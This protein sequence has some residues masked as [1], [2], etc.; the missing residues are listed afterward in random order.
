MV[1]KEQHIRNE[2]ISNE[3]SAKIDMA[4]TYINKSKLVATENKIDRELDNKIAYEFASET[5]TWIDDLYSLGSRF[6]GGNENTLVLHIRFPGS[7]RNK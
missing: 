5:N 6:L 4:H 3:L 7:G 1:L 2:K